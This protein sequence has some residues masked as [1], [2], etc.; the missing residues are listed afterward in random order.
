MTPASGL[1]QVFTLRRIAETPLSTSGELHGA[2][3]AFLSCILERG[4]HNPVHRRIP[5]GL[6]RINRKP[7]GASHFDATFR[8]MIGESY[9]GI[10]WLPD[11]P[12]RSNIEIHT[13]NFVSQLEGCLA[14]GG[15]VVRETDGD[16]AIAGGTS[17]PAFAHVY[18]ALSSAIDAGGAQLLIKDIE[19]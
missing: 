11:V 6:Y 16:F 10:L 5:A 9:K 7:F 4:A 15:A 14:T 3:G 17:R 12:G 8:R 1:P 18:A 2:D 13:A 19:Q